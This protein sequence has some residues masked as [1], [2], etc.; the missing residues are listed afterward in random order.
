MTCLWEPLCD[1]FSLERQDQGS[2]PEKWSR[3]TSPDEA[4]VGRGRIHW[5]ATSDGCRLGGRWPQN[6]LESGSGKMWDSH[7]SGGCF[8]S[9]GS[10]HKAGRRAAGGSWHLGLT[11]RDGPALLPFPQIRK[12]S[13]WAVGPYTSPCGLGRGGGVCF[14]W[15]PPLEPCI[16]LRGG[17]S[18]PKQ[19]E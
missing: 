13:D 12:G 7:L 4:V 10:H 19:G 9:A 8:L 1:A 6:C 14:N 18:S 15:Q 11:P 2:Q 5:L 3:N 17:S 16:F